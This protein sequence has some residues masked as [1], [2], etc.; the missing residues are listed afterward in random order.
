[1]QNFSFLAFTH[2]FW[3]TFEYGK[4]GNLLQPSSMIGRRAECQCLFCIK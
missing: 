2:R 3:R 4:N 1:V